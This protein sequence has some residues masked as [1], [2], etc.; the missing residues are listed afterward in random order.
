MQG[1]LGSIRKLADAH[2]GHRLGSNNDSREENSIL[3]II[4]VKVPCFDDIGVKDSIYK[5]NKFFDL[6]TISLEIRLSIV[7]FH[8]EGAP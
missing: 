4:W 2:P 6:Y 8:F 7:V 1:E 3:K 5:M